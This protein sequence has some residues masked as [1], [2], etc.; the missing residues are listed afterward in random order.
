MQ[1]RLSLLVCLSHNTHDSLAG[2]VTDGYFKITYTLH[3]VYIR[4]DIIIFRPIIYWESINLLYYYVTQIKS[5]SL[6][7]IEKFV[8]LTS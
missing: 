2:V 3:F 1:S 7:P 5:T 8:L 6:P 4:L